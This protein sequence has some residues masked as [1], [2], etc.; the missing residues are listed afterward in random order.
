VIVK[1]S[2]TGCSMENASI[3]GIHRFNTF[4]ISINTFSIPSR[5]VVTKVMG[6]EP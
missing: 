6:A 2:T 3:V 4:R 1:A 5:E